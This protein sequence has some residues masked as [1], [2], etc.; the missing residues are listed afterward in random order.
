[1][2]FDFDT[3]LDREQARC[4]EL[5]NDVEN[6]F[7]L[8]PNQDSIGYWMDQVFRLRDEAH[9]RQNDFAGKFPQSI[10]LKDRVKIRLRFPVAGYA[11]CSRALK[12]RVFR[13]QADLV[14]LDWEWLKGGSMRDSSLPWIKNTR[15]FYWNAVEGQLWAELNGE[16]LRQKLTDS[17]FG[18]YVDPL[19]LRKDASEIALFKNQKDL[20]LTMPLPRPVRSELLIE[21]KS[22]FYVYVCPTSFP[23]DKPVV[24]AVPSPPSS[25]P[26]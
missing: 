19:V 3:F 22:S 17:G 16:L 5:R 18:I 2:D 21:T 12:D 23:R 15:Q 14:G 26:R 25:G 1:M 7:E 20:I 10:P 4:R 24:S 6:R 13:V 11:E 9:R 8:E